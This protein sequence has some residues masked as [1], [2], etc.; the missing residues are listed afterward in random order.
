MSQC[1]HDRL[2]VKCEDTREDLC[3]YGY[4]VYGGLTFAIMA[5]PGFLF[6]FSEFMHFKAF[7]FG[8]LTGRMYGQNANRLL[9]FM[10]LP[11]YMA[12][13]APLTIVITIVT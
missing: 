10:L 6:A 5:A 8:A 12:V 9:K 11:V 3:P 4:L 1:S 13:M 7:R 2:D